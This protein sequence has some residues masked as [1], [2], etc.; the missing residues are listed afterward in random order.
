MTKMHQ[1]V[2]P[3][4]HGVTCAHRARRDAHQVL[5]DRAF[6]L[7]N[8]RRHANELAE[9]G[10]ISREAAS[11]KNW[12]DEIVSVVSQIEL[13]EAGVTIEQVQEA[14]VYMTATAATVQPVTIKGEAWVTYLGSGIRGFLVR[15]PGYRQGPA[16]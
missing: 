9:R 16:Y 3:E 11:Q 4:C 6:A 10:M 12:K 8:P 15:A 2:C 14:I 5:M 1:I 13:D 7:V